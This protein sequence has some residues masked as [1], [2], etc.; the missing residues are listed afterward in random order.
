MA[1]TVCD[2]TGWVCENHP[3]HP[4]DCGDSKRACIGGGAGMPCRV[5]NNPK[6]G[7]RPR[8]PPGFTPRDDADKE[9]IH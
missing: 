1:C 6:L 9:P 8:I 3:D 5:C 7:E 4:S 2:D